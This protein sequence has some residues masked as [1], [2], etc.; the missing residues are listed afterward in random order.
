MMDSEITIWE[1][2]AIDMK[3]NNDSGDVEYMLNEMAGDGWGLLSVISGTGGTPS[4]TKI[5]AYISK[6]PI[7]R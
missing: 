5:H 3:T 4:E 2:H 6:K 1:Y 7:V